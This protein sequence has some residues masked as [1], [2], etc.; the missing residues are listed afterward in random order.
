MGLDGGE[1]FVREEEHLGRCAR[2]ALAVVAQ[3]LVALSPSGSAACVSRGP[4]CGN[5]RPLI[6]SVRGGRVFRGRI[7][8]PARD[9]LGAVPATRDP[10]RAFRRFPRL[11]HGRRAHRPHGG[12]SAARRPHSGPVPSSASPSSSPSTP[13]KHA[14]RAAPRAMPAW[15]VPPSS[16]AVSTS[17]TPTPPRHDEV[18]RWVRNSF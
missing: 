8:G 2:R 9:P 1:D 3:G 7:Q 10:L 13:P 12:A 16:R 4:R 5:A 11:P 14:A 6:G 17:R 18:G 15:S